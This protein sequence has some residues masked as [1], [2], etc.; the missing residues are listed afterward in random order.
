M[1]DKLH[2]LYAAEWYKI[3][4]PFGI[5]DKLLQFIQVLIPY[6]TNVISKTISYKYKLL[7]KQYSF[8]S[9]KESDITYIPDGTLVS[10]YKDY[11]NFPYKY[12]VYNIKDNF[13]FLGCNFTDHIAL[14]G[15]D[16]IIKNDVYL[17]RE[18]P[19]KFCYVFNQDSKVVYNT[20]G[21]IGGKVQTV[22]KNYTKIPANTD[23]SIRIYDNILKNASNSSL[24]FID[25]YSKYVYTTHGLYGTVVQTWSYNNYKL[26]ILSTNGFVI[27]HKD[28]G[29][30]LVK[31]KT[32]YF[33]DNIVYF[34]VY[35]NN[36]YYPV[37][38][39]LNNLN[40]YPGLLDQYPELTVIDGL[41]LGLDLLHI[42]KN[43]GCNFTD[44]PYINTMNSDKY[45]LNETMKQGSKTMYLGNSLIMKPFLF[46]S[47]SEG[48]A[49][50]FSDTFISNIKVDI[51]YIY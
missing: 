20:I 38:R 16:Y 34:T 24:N 48:Y 1:F 23:T 26:A 51:K 27:A 18:H 37:Y 14:R 33:L 5:L 10:G 22:C 31:G 40:N 6:C 49:E 25:L 32:P 41:F 43:H 8:I 3:V 50:E 44:I 2:N 45:L 4:K 19:S 46:A 29:L 7:N 13:N 28:S 12:I 47:D 21:C 9:I 36:T 11:T 17:F 35:L 30:Q 15:I 39:E 42:L